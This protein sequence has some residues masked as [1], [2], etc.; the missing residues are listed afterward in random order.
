V[1]IK[2]VGLEHH[3]D[4]AFGRRQRIDE[5]AADANVPGGRGVESGDHPQKRGFAAARRADQDDEFAVV[6]GKAD[7]AKHVRR[8]VALI[9]TVD[10]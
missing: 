10:A 2:R 8:P 3:R 4:F 6:D 1:R 7:I 9:E 5:F